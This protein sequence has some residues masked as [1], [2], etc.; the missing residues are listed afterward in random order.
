MKGIFIILGLSASSLLITIITY[1]FNTKRINDIR[2]LPTEMI[3]KKDKKDNLVML[4]KNKK[5]LNIILILNAINLILPNTLFKLFIPSFTIVISTNLWIQLFDEIDTFS[6]T[7]GEFN[8]ILDYNKKQKE[9]V[10]KK[11]QERRIE[12]N[13]KD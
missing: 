3:S 12:K 6:A 1:F 5:I 13:T 9:E 7:K 8:V 4:D 11:A 10:Q 2:D